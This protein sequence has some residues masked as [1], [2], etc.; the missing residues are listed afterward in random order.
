M[1]GHRQPDER[2]HRPRHR[3]GL[4]AGR[5]RLAAREYAAREQDRD[6][7]GHRPDPPPVARRKG[8]VSDRHR[9]DARRRHPAPPGV[10]RG[11]DLGHRRGQPADLGR[12]RAAR[13]ERPHAS[14]GAKR[15]RRE[16][17]DHRIPRG[18]ARGGARPGRLH[19]HADA[20][21]LYRRHPRRG[22]R[23]RARP[24]EGLSA[25]RRGAGEAVRLGLP[26]LQETGGRAGCER[27]R[28]QRAVG[29]RDGGDPRL[30]LPA[31]LQRQRA[32]RDGG[33][34]ARPRGRNPRDRRD[35][36]RLP[37][38]LWHP[39]R[40]G[41]GRAAAAGRC[42]RAGECRGRARAGRLFHRRAG[43][44]PQG[45]ASAMHAQHGASAGRRSDRGAGHRRVA[46]ADAWGRGAAARPAGG[47]ARPDPRPH[48][49]HVRPD[50]DDDLVHHRRSG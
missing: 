20:A 24:N 9:G 30:R 35:R 2:A 7:R 43:A 15:R 25:R 18:A 8:R 12:G 5:L 33:R 48:T 1:G 45:H 40:D 28:P 34:R 29:R 44:A 46:D 41:A 16:A 17:A 23:D 37:D 50:R 32:V 26:G 47:T 22:G 3:L 6:V 10:E 27:H 42:G 39:D 31:L 49:E 4:A 21:H 38:R 19:R 13:R 14:S 11:S 36:D